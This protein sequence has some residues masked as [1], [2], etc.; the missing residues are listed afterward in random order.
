MEM[1]MAKEKSA[2]LPIVVASPST[3][4]STGT[5]GAVSKRADQRSG[6]FSD[7][8]SAALDKPV[9]SEPSE[10]KPGEKS[11]TDANEES[12]LKNTFP[13]L[14]V[15][16]VWS[17][18]VNELIVPATN[19]VNQEDSPNAASLNS[20]GSFNVLPLSIEGIVTAG[21][22]PALQTMV[23]GSMDKK[24][25]S[26]AEGSPVQPFFRESKTTA[27]FGMTEGMTPVE[28]TTAPFG[29]KTPVNAEVSPMTLKA[30]VRSVETRSGLQIASVDPKLL[31]DVLSIQVS[32]PPT[33]VKPPAVLDAIPIS[34][35]RLAETRPDLQMAS[36]DPKLFKDLSPI[37]APAATNTI[38]IVDVKQA[39]TKLDPQMRDFDLAFSQDV[40]PIQVSVDSTLAKSSMEP[41]LMPKDESKLSEARP[42]PI[43]GLMDEAAGQNGVSANDNELFDGSLG[44]A[45]SDSIPK[46]DAQNDSAAMAAV[47]FDRV[48]NSVDQ[49]SDATAVASQPRQDLHEVARQ[50]M[51]GMTISA[52]RLK[53]S[54]VI[55]TL[56]PEHLG[57]VTV[58]INVDGD[59]VTAAFH[60]A[61][62]EVRAILES[63]L[64]QL[65]QEMSQQGWN[66]DSNGVF[67]DMQEF[68]ANQ[69]QQ[70]QS[71]QE[72]QILQ[73]AHRL[74]REVYD[75]GMA[76]TPGGQPQI[77][78]AASVDYRI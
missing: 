49:S 14:A 52:D 55:I 9:Q 42:D 7:K 3:A 45:K 19:T 25:L 38:P 23:Q 29:M 11:N 44:H 63:S 2:S 69:Q 64:P 46:V 22:A 75:D 76:F 41:D 50:V 28:G 72:Q 57:E 34:G 62:S 20:A 17:L 10:Q 18:P 31:K 71:A 78:T 24:Y 77:M 4:T 21:V 48:L 67:G 47:T 26:L 56:K 16:M 59:R 54:Q 33:L 68:L 1:I 15:G 35:E 43:I 73:N 61:S 36:V 12:Q 37:Q 58:K 74:H 53:S 70:R 39:E 30:D 32:A 40:A 66:F 60:A 27:V 13:R 8:L 65:R 6:A 51:D 5:P